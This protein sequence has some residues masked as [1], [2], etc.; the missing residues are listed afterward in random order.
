[1]VTKASWLKCFICFLMQQNESAKM[2]DDGHN[3]AF[4]TH[5]TMLLLCWFFSFLSIVWIDRY[6][7]CRG[8]VWWFRCWIRYLWRECVT[9]RVE[10]ENQDNYLK[11]LSDL[12]SYYLMCHI[13]V[14][15][16]H[17]SQGWS[18]YDERFIRL[19]VVHLNLFCIT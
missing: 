5:I 13:N 3:M 2:P 7:A 11:I 18:D 10:Q 1:M 4:C 15:I 16:L 8:S 19:P 6:K 14:I 9:V 12:L 17:L